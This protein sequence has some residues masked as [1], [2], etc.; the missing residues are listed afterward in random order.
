M[1]TITKSSLYYPDAV[2]ETAE[3][4]DSSGEPWRPLSKRFLPAENPFI[5]YRSPGE[6]YELRDRMEKY[7]LEYSQS[8]KHLYLCYCNTDQ[9]QSGTLQ[10]H[11]APLMEA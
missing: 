2:K 10:L 3:I 11:I 7:K 5:S 1:L 8:L 4:I 6:M 9:V